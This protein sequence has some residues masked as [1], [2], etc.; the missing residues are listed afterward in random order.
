MERGG[1]FDLPSKNSKFKKERPTQQGDN[2]NRGSK[3]LH[4]C[5]LWYL[6]LDASCQLHDI[7]LFVVP[8][9]EIRALGRCFVVALS[10]N[11]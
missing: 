9:F 8:I 11:I 6:L 7:V 5:Y 3:H 4:A 10:M 1:T 2:N